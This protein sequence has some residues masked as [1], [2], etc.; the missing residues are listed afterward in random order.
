G[1]A[2]GESVLV[3]GFFDHVIIANQRRRVHVVA[4]RYSEVVVEAVIDRS[5]RAYS[6]KMPFPDAGCRVAA[7]L[8]RASNCRFG[9]RQ[10]RFVV[11]KKHICEMH[12]IDAH[13]SGISTGHQRG[14]RWSAN[15]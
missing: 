11:R 15:R 7:S 2:L 1:V 10:T 6:T 5:M 8:Q 12:L 13:A 14:S 9:L 4:V 3:R